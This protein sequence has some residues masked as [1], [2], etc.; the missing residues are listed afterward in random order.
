MDNNPH[1]FSKALSKSQGTQNSMATS[2]E[3]DNI[4]GGQSVIR[5]T[6]GI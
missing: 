2:Q 6:E 4:F 3:K 5:G 1:P